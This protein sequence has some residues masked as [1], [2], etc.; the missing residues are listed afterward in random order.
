MFRGK[1]EGAVNLSLVT[2]GS[3][4]HERQGAEPGHQRSRIEHCRSVSVQFMLESFA[5]HP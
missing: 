3:R 2:G 4:G 1:Q 5:P